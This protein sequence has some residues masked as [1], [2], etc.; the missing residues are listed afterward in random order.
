[1]HRFIMYLVNLPLRDGFQSMGC[2]GL[3]AERAPDERA[4]KIPDRHPTPR[5]RAKQGH[6]LNLGWLQP[7]EPPAVRRSGREN[8]MART[9][10]RSLSETHATIASAT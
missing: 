2:E 9:L 5:L 6:H 1:M 3:A 10:D 7:H 4:V 8:A